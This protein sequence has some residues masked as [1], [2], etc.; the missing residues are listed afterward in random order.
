M[1]GLGRRVEFDE[2]S[3]N[4]PIRALLPRQEVRQSKIWPCDI[5]LD[6]GNDG[7]CVGFAY[8]H[9]LIAE[10]VVVT[11][12]AEAFA[13]ELAGAPLDY[14]FAMGIY[15]AAQL[16]D[17]WDDTPP[18]EGTSVLAGAKIVTQR[19]YYEGYRWAFSLDDIL[20]TLSSKGPGVLGANWYSGMFTPDSNNVIHVAGIVEGGHGILTH[21]VDFDGMFGHQNHALV[22]QSWGLPWG[23]DGSAWI[24][25]SDL[26]RV[27]HEDGEFCVPIGRLAGGVPVV[28]PED[29]SGCLPKPMA[30]FAKWMGGK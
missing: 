29:K 8:T 26:E 22:H 30:R 5:T 14:N 3:R 17:Q 2:Q 25:F 18:E 6:Q 1:P 16:I 13:H 10:P 11:G 7:A 27:F 24:P 23:I 15:R 20:D 28:P 9:E 19:G 12:V 21:G 4:F